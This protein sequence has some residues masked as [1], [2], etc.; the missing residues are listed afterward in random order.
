MANHAA[1]ILA[2]FWYEVEECEGL[3]FRLRG[4]TGMQLFDV[5]PHIIRDGENTSWASA[6]V[7]AALRAGLVGWEGLKDEDGNDVEFGKDIDKNIARLDFVKINEVFAKIL[8]ASNL[9]AEQVK[10]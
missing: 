2:P 5:K 3:K 6:G 1:K 10:N 4:L 8:E 9:G 7:R